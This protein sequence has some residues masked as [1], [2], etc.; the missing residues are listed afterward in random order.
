M[1]TTSRPVA[2]AKR[3]VLGVR[4]GGPGP[5]CSLGRASKAS[6][7]RYP[8]VTRPAHSAV[9]ALARSRKVRVNCNRAAAPLWESNG[10]RNP[11][12]AYRHRAAVHLNLT[13]RHPRCPARVRLTLRPVSERLPG[14]DYANG[15]NAGPI[16]PDATSE[17]DRHSCRNLP[18]RVHK[19]PPRAYGA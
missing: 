2:A 14:C 6:S 15:S 16:N 3:D 13:S 10:L 8:T 19:A 11:R 17:L 9:A 1:A 18:M 7:V 4:L 12:P 5:S